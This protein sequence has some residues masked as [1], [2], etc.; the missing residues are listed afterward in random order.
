MST[1]I[2]RKLGAAPK[3]TYPTSS[4]YRC[5]LDSNV[6]KRTEIVPKLLNCPRIRL[7]SDYL[8]CHHRHLPR[9]VTDIGAKINACF[10]SRP[11]NGSF[12]LVKRQNGL[13]LAGVA[14]P[15]SSGKV[16]QEAI[17]ESLHHMTT[18]ACG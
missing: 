14:A 9:V 7:E 10:P 17:L 16:L 3:Y 6:G 12:K 18:L 1:R 11:G 5:F 8:P 2:I 4:A 15:M 13:V